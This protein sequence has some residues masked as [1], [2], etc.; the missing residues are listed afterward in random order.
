M[1]KE[2]ILILGVLLAIYNGQFLAQK[3]I[4]W[5]RTGFIIRVGLGLL[6]YP[7]ILYMLIYFNVAWSVYDIIINKYLKA[8]WHYV[9]R[10]SW[11]D[12]TIPKW[13]NLGLKILL[14]VITLIYGLLKI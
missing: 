12:K 7:N 11:I 9:G 3:P 14:L 6:L 8:S 1:E 2:I 10:T 5:H 4:G 13:L